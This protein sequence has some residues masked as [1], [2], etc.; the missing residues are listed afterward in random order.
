MLSPHSSLRLSSACLFGFESR[1]CLFR[2]TPRFVCGPSAGIAHGVPRPSP[3]IAAKPAPRLGA[4]RHGHRRSAPPVPRAR[5]LLLL[6]GAGAHPGGGALSRPGPRGPSFFAK[7]HLRTACSGRLVVSVWPGESAPCTRCGPAG[8]LQGRIVRSPSGVGH[9]PGNMGAQCERVARKRT[10][11]D[12]PH[13]SRRPSSNSTS[14]CRR[15]ATSKGA[16]CVANTASA[17]A[18]E[19]RQQLWRHH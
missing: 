18:P 10:L 3:A 11:V 8:Q 6:I 2:P 13:T 12:C 17:P 19:A 1:S 7:V 16:P 9:H 5:H 4:L 14:P 15:P